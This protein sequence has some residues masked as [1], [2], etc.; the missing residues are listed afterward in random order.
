MLCVLEN[1]GR[2][3]V[4][5]GGVTANRQLM[6]PK[7]RTLLL[8]SAL[9]PMFKDTARFKLKPCGL[10][11]VRVQTK[12]KPSGQAPAQLSEAAQRELMELCED[13]FA[14]LEKVMSRL[15]ARSCT[16][17]S[18]DMRYTVPTVC[19]CLCCS[20]RMKLYYASPSPVKIRKNR[21]DD[22][23]NDDDFLFLS[24]CYLCHIKGNCEVK[25]LLFF[26]I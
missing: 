1:I 19:L 14:Q 22:N 6:A 13:Q 17:R 7:T 23:D 12:E 3:N 18:L 4:S 15:N 21:W 16:D 8:Y 9:Y 24:S 2:A 26:H 25:C 10:F 5:S 20:F 11:R